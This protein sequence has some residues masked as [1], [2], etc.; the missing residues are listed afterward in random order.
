MLVVG[1]DLAL[2]P[3]D[4]AG[5]LQQPEVAP[6]PD[7]RLLHRRRPADRRAASTASPSS[8]PRGRCTWPSA[9]TGSRSSRAGEITDKELA[10]AQAPALREV[11][12]DRS[13][14]WSAITVPACGTAGRPVRGGWRA[15][16]STCGRGSTCPMNRSSTHI[17]ANAPRPSKCSR[18][19]SPSAKPLIDA[20]MREARDAGGARPLA[21]G[22]S[23]QGILDRADRHRT[24]A[25]PL[26]C[27]DFDPY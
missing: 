12:A 3:A 13:A 24:T 25:R 16:K 23:S 15:T 11:A 8:R 18:R 26:A 19:A 22:S 21:A 9:A 20:A 1:C 17:R 7:L 4:L 10:A 6:R 14:V 27:V 5:D 2:G